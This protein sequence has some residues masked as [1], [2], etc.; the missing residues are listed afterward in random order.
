MKVFCFMLYFGMHH[1]L[2]ELI[3]YPAEYQ[4]KRQNTHVVAYT[5]TLCFNAIKHPKASLL[6]SR[7][8]IVMMIL[9]QVAHCLHYMPSVATTELSPCGQ[10]QENYLDH[11]RKWKIITHPETQVNF[12]FVKFQLIDS[13]IGCE[14]ESL[15]IECDVRAKGQVSVYCGTKYTWDHF[16]L[17]SQ[18]QLQYTNPLYQPTP[19]N[20]QFHVKYQILQ[21]I[22]K[23]RATIHIKLPHLERNENVT[24]NRQ[25]SSV[26]RTPLLIYTAIGNI[27]SITMLTLVSLATTRVSLLRK[28]GL[29]EECGHIDIW[30]DPG[31]ISPKLLPSM[32]RN[33][34]DLEYK[35]NSFVAVVIATVT[36]IGC[37]TDKLRLIAVF[38]NAIYFS[39]VE[40]IDLK[41]ASNRFNFT[42]LNAPTDHFYLDVMIFEARHRYINVSVLVL[43]A[44]GP[45]TYDCR[46]WGLLIFQTSRITTRKKY[47]DH[48]L[49]FYKILQPL[50]ILCKSAQGRHGEMV[51]IP[52]DFISNSGSIVAV[53]YSH[54]TRYSPF[55]V[56]AMIT[57]T[58]CPGV[59]LYCGSQQLH[60]GSFDIPQ[61][62]YF[63]DS[64]PNVRHVDP[65]RTKLCSNAAVSIQTGDV[66]LCLDQKQ[67]NKITNLVIPMPGTH[68]LTIHHL[69]Y[70]PNGVMPWGKAAD[71]VFVCEMAISHYS[72]RSTDNVGLVTNRINIRSHMCGE[73]DV[74]QQYNVIPDY[75][76]TK[77]QFNPLCS[78]LSVHLSK[79]SDSIKSLI[80]PHLTI[81]GLKNYCYYTPSEHY[82]KH[83]EHYVSNSKLSTVFRSYQFGGYI[84]FNYA[85]VSQVAMIDFTPTFQTV[86]VVTMTM[87]DP[88]CARM[89]VSINF[90]YS[91]P[92]QMR[93]SGFRHNEQEYAQKRVICV[94]RSDSAQFVEFSL[95]LERYA[96]IK[97]LP[98]A[99]NQTC[100]AKLSF[101]PLYPISRLLPALYE[102]VESPCCENQSVYHYVIWKDMSLSWTD[103]EAKCNDIG[104]HLPLAASHEELSLLEHVI[105][106]TRF[107]SGKTPHVSPIR[108][109][110]HSGVFLGFN[111]PK[112]RR[113]FK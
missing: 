52:R 55:S 58:A 34:V 45:T 100:Q 71:N 18:A 4:G 9:K 103:A 77:V 25:Y 98:V 61:P 106:G 29:F 63:L 88:M 59:H 12:T 65:G 51:P 92:T 35:S 8:H 50:F 2:E 43:N 113:S 112:V 5:K 41:Q 91:V 74:F 1:A 107:N 93:Q 80:P 33:G 87:S 56:T 67:V 42:N 99:G 108:F 110:P 47:R 31:R 60:K 49:L 89:C 73:E 30:G 32:S 94:G 6:E 46:H 76:A 82:S 48:P 66:L 7:W 83:L 97:A 57:H 14:S 85:E 37:N 111:N 70:Y 72:Y 21:G 86:T 69:Y 78:T 27:H 102:S 22:R 62:R 90:T 3:A 96:L 54:N 28:P 75:P 24:F 53:W 20:S 101:E 38:Y 44:V 13:V 39:K 79:I 95:Y 19:T 84:W 11:S 64:I 109:H 36:H 40:K 23:S 15:A 105:L 10:I 26:W 16:C 17:S 81:I 68:C 104:G